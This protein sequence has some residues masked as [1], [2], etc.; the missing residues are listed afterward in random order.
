[1]IEMKDFLDFLKAVNLLKNI[2][3]ASVRD[4][5]NGNKIVIDKSNYPPEA[6]FDLEGDKNERYAKVFKKLALV[7][8]KKFV[9]NRV[10]N[11]KIKDKEVM[12]ASF[13]HLF[14]GVSGQVP[15]E[16]NRL[17]SSNYT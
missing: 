5:W 14:Q 7:Y 8:F 4:L 15:F 1:M 2:S 10:Y 11:S 3:F 9:P 16:T 17:L 13:T 12:I 6:K